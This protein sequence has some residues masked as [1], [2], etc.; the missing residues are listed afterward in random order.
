ML[1]WVLW[2][3]FG[4]RDDLISVCIPHPPLPLQGGREKKFNVE[5]GE[6][7]VNAVLRL[8]FLFSHFPTGIGLVSLSRV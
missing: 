5:P 8:R 4:G 1:D 2:A 3:G 6:K 7:G